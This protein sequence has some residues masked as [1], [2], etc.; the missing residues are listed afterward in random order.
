MEAIKKDGI[1]DKYIVDSNTQIHSHI[2]NPEN[3][4]VTSNT[5][6]LRAKELCP[7]TASE[8]EIKAAFLKILSNRIKELNT[9]YK[10]VQAHE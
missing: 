5:L 8:A 3:W 10:N 1:V 6:G 4:V 7:K 9:M 2:Y